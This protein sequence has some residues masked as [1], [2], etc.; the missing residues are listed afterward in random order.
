MLPITAVATALCRRSWLTGAWPDWMAAMPVPA[1]MPPMISGMAASTNTVFRVL[2]GRDSRSI[3]DHGM[4]GGACVTPILEHI[5]AASPE[6][7]VRC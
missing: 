4:P 2:S 6:L 5:Q 3:R 1:M 7:I